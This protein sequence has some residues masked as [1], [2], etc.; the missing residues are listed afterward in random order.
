MRALIVDPSFCRRV[1]CRSR[2][3]VSIRDECLAHRSAPIDTVANGAKQ[4]RGFR[5]RCDCGFA[6]SLFAGS[7]GEPCRRAVFLGQGYRSV[8]GKFFLLFAALPVVDM[9]LLVRI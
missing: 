9:Y 5:W 3:S 2:S 4:R 1:T 8:V 6:Y 7:V